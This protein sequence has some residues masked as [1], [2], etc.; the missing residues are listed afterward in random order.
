M[1]NRYIDLG[2]PSGLLWAANNE[3]DTHYFYLEAVKKFGSSL[4]T[5]NQFLELLEYTDK[6][7]D[8]QNRGMWFVSKINGNKIY[9]PAEGEYC[10]DYRETYLHHGGGYYWTSSS[11]NDERG[12]VGLHFS[13]DGVN[14]VWSSPSHGK[15]VRLVKLR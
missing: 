5:D 8:L 7:W 12:R 1:E 6:Y 9:L 10:K 2:L 3:K 11:K 4:P 13:S 14:L 15:S